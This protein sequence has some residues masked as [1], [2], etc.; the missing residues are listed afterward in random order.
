MADPGDAMLIGCLEQVSKEIPVMTRLRRGKDAIVLI[1]VIMSVLAVCG[2]TDGGGNS[3][4]LSVPSPDD[5]TYPELRNAECVD[6]HAPQYNSLENGRGKHAPL[7]CTFC[8]I[9][10]G[11]LPDCRDCH[12]ETHGATV[13]ACT[14]CHP[15]PHA[16]VERINNSNL[17]SSR[18]RS[19]HVPQ[20]EGIEESG[21]LH[22]ALE[23]DHCHIQHGYLPPCSDC[24]G[25]PHG[26]DALDCTNCHDPHKPESIE[27]DEHDDSQCARCHGSFIKETFMRKHTR[28]ADI[29][30]D[31]CH[32]EHAVTM[33]CIDCHAGHNTGMGMR[34]CTN[35]H[36]IGHVP[37]EIKYSADTTSGMCVD[38]H[39]EPFNTMLQS[40]SEHA[41]IECVQCHPDHGTTVTCTS[42]GCHT[43]DQSHGSGGK[44]TD[45]H[46]QAH[47][48]TVG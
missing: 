5:R 40:G 19:C 7:N 4:P 6:C 16:P 8:H 24:H 27:F 2:C 10:H 46:D 25:L 36:R 20:Y 21:G 43:M 31:M 42:D 37:L 18:C 29:A 30:C 26:S 48:L 17:N 14:S 45:C 11:Y 32:P 33:L 34:D 44:C 9:Q 13:I 28:H 47:N 41:Y 12:P 22:S 3:E 39:A 1:V 35:C 23:C 38:C 15:D